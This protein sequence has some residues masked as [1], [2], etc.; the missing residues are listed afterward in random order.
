MASDVKALLKKNQQLTHSECVKVVSHKQR[1]KDG[2]FLNTVMI[3]N[4]DTPF[5]FKR[6][7]PYKALNGARVNITY[8][9][10][11][12]NVAGLDFEIMKVVR[13]KIA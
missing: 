11:T 4:C 3:E 12:E 13:I 1:E 9:P 2:W 8:Y 10:E 6:Q 5:K 7:Q